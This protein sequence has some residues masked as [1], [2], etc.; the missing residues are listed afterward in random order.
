MSNNSEG[1][2]EKVYERDQYRNHQIRQREVQLRNGI[3]REREGEGRWWE[4]EGIRMRE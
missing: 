2:R 3:E 1:K 4:R